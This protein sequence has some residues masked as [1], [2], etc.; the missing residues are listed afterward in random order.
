V[1]CG[2]AICGAGEYCC[3]PSCGL[4]APLGGSCIEIACLG[5]GGAPLCG[6]STCAA[7]ETCC[8]GCGPDDGICVPPRSPCPAFDCPPPPPLWT[9]CASALAGG[10]PGDACFGAF[11]CT[12]ESGSC[13]ALTASCTDGVL[14]LGRTCIP[15]CF[16]CVAQD[17]RGVGDCRAIVGIFWNGDRCVTESGCSCEGV[18]C[19]AGYPSTGECR[20]AHD[21][22]PRVGGLCGTRGP[23]PCGPGEICD[24]SSDCGA[25]D[26]GGVCIVPPTACPDIY[27]PVCGCDGVTYG[28]VCE[29]H[30]AGSDARSA[31]EC[32]ADDCRARGCPTGTT[33]E[34]CWT[35]WEC[36]PPGVAC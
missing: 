19:S 6:A 34:L 27:A 16:D 17:A 23:P 8:P 25:A 3:N 36:L 35:T 1:A 31:G 9:D 21:T 12:I 5:D 18:D 28:N 11:S 15:E 26:T 20:L 33:C 32:G 10:S 4:C 29:A 30:A 7:S 14:A 2:S 24:Y 13:C 22:C